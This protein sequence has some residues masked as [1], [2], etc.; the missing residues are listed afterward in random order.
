MKSLKLTALLLI[1][2]FSLLNISCSPQEE[3]PGVSPQTKLGKLVYH[4]LP[5]FCLENFTE[6]QEFAQS[7]YVNQQKHLF[8]T[9]RAQKTFYDFH[10]KLDDEYFEKNRISLAGHSL[11]EGV[12]RTDVNISYL[13][14]FKK[15]GFICEVHIRTPQGYF[16]PLEEIRKLAKIIAL[17]ILRS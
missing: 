1:L 11:Y 3:K 8:L 17:K 7:L 5:D 16:R 6:N 4:E 13:L 14:I 2:I 9:V 12:N 15:K 10:K